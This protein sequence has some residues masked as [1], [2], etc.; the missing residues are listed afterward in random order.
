MVLALLRREIGLVSSSMAVCGEIKSVCGI[1]YAPGFLVVF[2]LG[3]IASYHSH[4]EGVLEG[5]HVG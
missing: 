2:G 1:I 5:G 4:A 3:R